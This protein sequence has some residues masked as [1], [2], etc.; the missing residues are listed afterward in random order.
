MFFS[1][2]KMASQDELISQSKV[3]SDLIE[4]SLTIV[5]NQ[6]CETANGRNI[7]KKRFDK[8]DA[9]IKDTLKQIR[10]FLKEVDEFF[11]VEGKYNNNNINF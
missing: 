5:R 3:L 8:L 1:S 10:L 9:L 11:K 4:R 2:S 7:D 6:I